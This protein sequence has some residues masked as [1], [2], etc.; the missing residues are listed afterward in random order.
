MA[1]FAAEGKVTEV[2][3]GSFVLLGFLAVLFGLL[4]VLFPGLSTA[5]LMELVGIFIILF[6]FGVVVMSAISPG[7]IRGSILLAILGVIGF[8]FGI[9][10]ILSP[11]VMGGVIFTLA[12]I[13]LFIGGLLGLILAASEKS[14]PHRGLYALQAVLTLIIGVA[15]IVAPVIGA[16]LLVLLLGAYFVVWGILAIISGTMV[17]MAKK[18]MA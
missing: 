7:G 3:G 13:A 6:S 16:A 1:E 5:V 9:A 2:K 11:Y 12:G 15:I 18:S 8:F 10:T 17:I 4:I 14:I